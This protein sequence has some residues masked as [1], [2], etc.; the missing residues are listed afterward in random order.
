MQILLG[1]MES[2]NA[3]SKALK[4]AFGTAKGE[5]ESYEAFSSKTKKSAITLKDGTRIELGALEYVLQGPSCFKDVIEEVS[6]EGYR[7]LSVAINQQ[8]WAILVIQDEIRTS[9]KETIQFFK[10][11]H[12]DVKIISGDNPLTVSR[13]A[14]TCGVENSEKYISLANVPLE[15]IDSLMEEYTIFGR[16]SPEQKEKIVNRYLGKLF[17]HSPVDQSDGIIPC[18][19]VGNIIEKKNN[20]ILND[21]F[22]TEVINKRGVYWGSA[23]IEEKRLSEIYLQ[24]AKELTMRYPSTASIYYSLSSMYKK[25]YLIERSAEEDAEY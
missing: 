20:R 16:V 13:I 8:E 23:G 6:L 11:N 15:E 22:V 4:E 10:D 1:A 12:V 3:T 5:I 24:T 14:K 7:V 9:A 2:Q 18:N 17:A 25:E 21:G 19:V